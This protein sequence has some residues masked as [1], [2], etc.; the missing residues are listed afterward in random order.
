M[1]QQINHIIVMVSDMGRAVE[2]YQ[3][4][5]GF[6]LKFRSE[7]WSE[8]DA[9]NVTFALHGGGKRE[10]VNESEPHSNAAGTASISFDVTDVEQTYRE[11]SAKGVK[12]SLAP[13]LRQGEGIKLAVA[14][15]LDGFEICFAQRI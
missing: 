12:F 10:S 2:F 13:T 1:F 7:N 11:L 4:V 5:M 8:L 9:G 6:K 15:D 14:Q 3:S